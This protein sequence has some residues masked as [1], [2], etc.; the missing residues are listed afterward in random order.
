MAPRKPK[1]K[2]A[3]KR[4]TSAY[5]L[6]VKDARPGVVKK[7]PKASITD[8][9]KL[10][11]KEYKKLSKAQLA[12][13][14]KEADKLKTAYSKKL[15]AYKKTANYKKFQKQLNEWKK[16]KKD[17]S[18]KKKTTKKATKKPAKKTTKKKKT[19]KKGKGSRKKK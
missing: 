9:A 12:K 19:A 18:T 10:L 8:I 5:F 2:N 17:T 15:A 3:P 11:G 4:P 13:Y 7:N 6:F 14:Q 1:D 16:A